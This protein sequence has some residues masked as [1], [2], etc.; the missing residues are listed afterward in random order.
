MD[1]PTQRITDMWLTKQLTRLGL[2]SIDQ[3]RQVHQ[4]E[5]DALRMSDRI[6]AEP[7]LASKAGSPPPHM[8]AAPFTPPAGPRLPPAGDSPLKTLAAYVDLEKMRALGPKEIEAVWR[9]RHADS[10]NSLCATIPAETFQRMNATARQ[11]A[12]FVLPLPAGDGGMISMHYVEW[13]FASPTIVVAIITHLD[14]YKTRGEFATPHTVITHHLDLAPDKRLVLLHASV[15][16]HCGV[17]TDD[18][19]WLLLMLQRFYGGVA[20]SPHRLTLLSRFNQGSDAFRMDELLEMAATFA[21][22][23]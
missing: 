23:S 11:H 19:R 17:S 1:L 9:L 8:A 10:S 22:T 3:L 2:S 4:Q 13:K 15:T 16:D 6:L 21:D 20:T 5:I 7:S 18:A 14:E 12:R